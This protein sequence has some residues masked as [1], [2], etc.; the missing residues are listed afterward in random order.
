MAR[1]DTPELLRRRAAERF[2]AGDCRGA[3]EDYAALIAREPSPAAFVN[4]GYCELTLGDRAAAQSSFK[5][6]LALH[7]QMAEALVGM[8]D[9]SAAR[10]EHADAVRHYDAALAARPGFALARN[11]RA[12]SRLALGQLRAALEDAESRYEASAALSLYPHRLA[13]PRWRGE[14]DKRV[15]VHWEQ[16][17]GDMIQFLRYLPCLARRRIDAVFEC[18]PPLTRLVAHMPGAPRWIAARHE[19]PDPAGFDACLPLLSLPLLLGGRWQDVPAPP[20]LTADERAAARLAAAWRKPD[21]NPRTGDTAPAGR[22]GIV[23]RASGFDASRSASLQS[24]LELAGAGVRLVSLQTGLSDD[25]R[26]MLARHGVPDA[27][28]DFGDFRDTAAA[29]AAVDRLITVDTATAH[30]AGALNR[31]AWLMLN[32]PAATRWMLGREDSPWYPAMRLFRKRNDEPWDA[33]LARL[34][35]ALARE[36]SG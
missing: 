11:N 30:L 26:G 22:T 9:A 17:Y 35:A 25:E 36:S 12:Q 32:Q 14:P 31:P 7:P 23:W 6:A 13:L 10:D 27:G 1:S 19:A 21:A 3:L 20:Y 15:L 33:L 4:R 16:G 29:L 24:M 2:D 8:G 5:A 28:S 34:R 18:P